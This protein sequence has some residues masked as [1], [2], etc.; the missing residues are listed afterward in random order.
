MTEDQL[1]SLIEEFHVPLHIRRHSEKVEEFSHELGEQLVKA[2]EKIDLELLRQSALLHDIVRLVDFKH[3]NPQKFHQPI[4]KEDLEIWESIRKKYAGMHHAV[5]AAKI[6]RE[7]G[8]PKI[9]QVVEKHRYLQIK[10]GF[11]TWEEKLLYYAD[12]RVKHDE[13]VPL[14]ERLNDGRERNAP[15]TKHLKETIETDQKV[16]ALEKEIMDAIKR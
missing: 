14:E 10:E 9:A 3:F 6:L 5:A 16:F 4:T 8:F 7:R 12:K 11:D 13:I 2:G 15:E 1:Q